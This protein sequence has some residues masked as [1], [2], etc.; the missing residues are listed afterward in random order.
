[1]THTENYNLPQWEAHDPVRRE[2][3]NQAMETIDT[4]MKAAKTAGETAQTAALMAQN[5]ANAAYRPGNM[6][7]VAGSYRGTGNTQTIT[8]G[9]RPSLLIIAGDESSSTPSAHSSS[10]GS[11]FGVVTADHN[12]GSVTLTETGFTVTDNDTCPELNKGSQTFAYIAFR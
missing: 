5:T 2:D 7:Y 8:L 12:Y 6:P 3:F 4:S 9:F 10:L 1:M 11:H